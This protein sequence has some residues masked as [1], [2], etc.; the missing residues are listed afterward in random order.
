MKI[1]IIKP[2]E[3]S[4]SLLLKDQ[5]TRMAQGKGVASPAATMDRIREERRLYPRIPCFLLVDYATQGCAYR[6]FVRNISA[7]GVFIESQRPVPPGP[8]VSLVISFPDDQS[9]I[10]MTGNIAWIGEQGIGV[11]FNPV[12][13]LLP[14]K[15][16]S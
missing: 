8:Q 10:K 13:A 1:W 11:K 14:E 5:I 7:D 15:P 12:E 3:T 9:P 4:L 6:A 16:R 2:E